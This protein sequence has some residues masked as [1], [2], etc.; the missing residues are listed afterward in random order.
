MSHGK[1][2]CPECQTLNDAPEA[3][4]KKITCSN[5]GMILVLNK[6]Y[7]DNWPAQ[8]KKH[9]TSAAPAK[10]K[11]VSRRQK[12]QSGDDIEEGQPSRKSRGTSR[13]PTRG[14]RAKLTKDDIIAEEAKHRKE[15][16][17]QRKA[18]AGMSP[19]MIYGSIGLFIVMGVVFALV[20]KNRSDKQAA[21]EQAKI[22]QQEKLKAE[23]IAKRDKEQ[24]EIDAAGNENLVDEGAK[25]ATD[26]KTAATKSTKPKA[27]KKKLPRRKREPFPEPEMKPEV[28]ETLKKAIATL[29]DLDATRELRGA[30]DIL[31]EHRKEAIP[32]L[33]NN[34]MALDSSTED[35]CR[36]A[37]PLLDVLR[38]CSEFSTKFDRNTIVTQW[39]DDPAEIKNNKEI[40]EIIAL[41]WWKWW[42]KNKATWKPP[43]ESEE[44]F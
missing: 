28:A 18:K 27:K 9:G 12:P 16:S 3:G 6:I 29:K 13:R 30:G 11:I 20:W 35:D 25:A 40:R 5:C 7:G 31:Y 41:D 33:I 4:T 15:R 19:A 43:V 2:P 26:E 36:R 39:S 38:L 22:E 17:Q 21:K 34:L 24:A 1:L 42:D 32:L 23:R 14:K 8:A 44:D 37:W 10:P